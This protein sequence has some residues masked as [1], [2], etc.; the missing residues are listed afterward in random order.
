MNKRKANIFLVFSIISILLIGG[1]VLARSTDCFTVNFVNYDGTK[2]T[3]LQDVPLGTQLY[4]A[5]ELQTLLKEEFTKEDGASFYLYYDGG[6]S[7]EPWGPIAIPDPGRGDKYTFRDW[8]KTDQDTTLTVMSN[9]DFVARYQS[10]SCYVI[11]LYFQYDDENQV[12]AAQTESH[13][14]EINDDF[15]INIPEIEGTNRKIDDTLSSFYNSAANKFEG[16]LTEDTI[17]QLE[18]YTEIDNRGNTVISIPITYHFPTN[19][20]YTVEYYEQN[21]DGKTY[22]KYK[23]E[24]YTTDDAEV[25][26]SGM[27][28]VDEI[29]HFTLTEAS[30]ADADLYIVS[31]TGNSVIKLYYNRD[32]YWIY[33]DSRGGTY[34]E[35]VQYLYGQTIEYGYHPT[36]QGYSFDGWDYSYTEDGVTYNE[37][38]KTM[39]GGDVHLTAKWSEADTTYRIVYWIERIPTEVDSGLYYINKGHYEEAK[40][41]TGTDLHAALSNGELNQ[42]ISSHLGDFIGADKVNYFEFDKEETLK[43]N[44]TN[45]IASGDGM[46]TINVYFK[47][48]TYTL[49]FVLAKYSRSA[50]RFAKGTSAGT[51]GGADWPLNTT[52][53]WMSSFVTEKKPSITLNGKDVTE[54][55]TIDGV[56]YVVYNLEAKYEEYIYD[57]WPRSGV[58]SAD[59]GDNRVISWGTQNDSGYYATHTNKNILG[60]Y[61]EM[62]EELIINASDPSKIHY[63]V[64][65]C[66]EPRYFRYHVMTENINQSDEVSGSFSIYNGKRYTEFTN[67]YSYSTNTIS[68]QNAMELLGFDF[69]GR[70]VDTATQNGN[71]GSSDANHPVELYFYYDRVYHNITLYNVDREYKLTQYTEA[72]RDSLLKEYGIKIDNEGNVSVKTGAT[73]KELQQLSLE[74][75]NDNTNPLDYPLETLGVNKEWKFNGWYRNMIGT[76][77]ANDAYWNAE[78]QTDR[79]LYA[80][81]EPPKY[82]ITYVV[83]NGELKEDFSGLIKLDYTLEIK[84]ENNAQYITIGNIPEGTGT[85]DFRGRGHL[86]VNDFGLQF[87]RWVYN[88][89]GTDREYMFTD[90]RK[91][92]SDLVLT[93]QWDSASSGKYTAYYLTEDKDAAIDAD[94]IEVDGKVYYQL[95]TTQ[96]V[97]NLVYGHTIKATAIE[98]PGYLARSATQK[99]VLDSDKNIYFIYDKAGENITYYVHYV[100]DL[101]VDYGNTQPPQNAE[102]LM[103]ARQVDL[104]DMTNRASVVES[105]V[106]ISGYTPRDGWSSKLVLSSDETMNHLYIYY[107]KNNATS[108][109]RIHYYFMDD[110][111]KYLTENAKTYTFTGI[112]PVGQF[113]YAK[114]WAS[115]YKDYIDNPSVITEIDNCVA[116]YKLDESLSDEYTVVGSSGTALEGKETDLYIYM[117]IHECTIT[118]IDS[119]TTENE[120]VIAQTKVERESTLKAEQLQ[121]APE[122]DGYAFKGWYKNAECTIPYN[123]ESEED[124]RIMNKENYLYAGW[125]QIGTMPLDENDK[126]NDMA[127]EGTNLGTEFGLVGVQ[128]RTFEINGFKQG[129]RFI[130][131]IGDTLVKD[132][133]DLNTK[134]GSLKP[135]D[136]HQK[137]VGYGTVVTMKKILPANAILVKDET[138]TSVTRGNV[139]VPAVVTFAKGKGYEYYSAVI[140]DMPVK[141]YGERA[142]VRPYITY[143]DCNGNIQDYYYTESGDKAYGKGYS[144]S[145]IETTDY[146]LNGGFYENSEFE[147]VEFLQKIQEEYQAY[148]STK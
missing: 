146:V 80:Q 74:W 129:L 9:I 99:F 130:S 105:A 25:S 72:Q 88:D 104:T 10:K 143:Y 71:Y 47:R 32:T 18:K 21:V 128:I 30:V 41:V 57:R 111:G 14:Y 145:Y 66:D 96:T 38:P 31:G 140:I 43:R 4:S 26:I 91:L 90:S 52:P 5:K 27:G 114:E 70:V 37:Q 8:K 63:M 55:K 62:S 107:T 20:P 36:R 142:V 16:K 87:K 124:S 109:F 93:A 48:K 97:S 24:T 138:A 112:A 61:G 115:N 92:Y 84:K 56:Q 137:G 77:V 45:I 51:V 2:T 13:S 75:E 101:G 94:A 73:L 113:L 98:I 33:R 79:V 132:L 148:L 3:T 126:I 134:N 86:P 127:A 103:E 133:E 117:E 65:F 35:P 67:F 125:R 40:T 89:N 122:H 17:K 78:V 50:Y 121:S 83:P 81:W 82:S 53:A 59:I 28:C 85:Y 100:K 19:T 68:N 29:P 120:G 76:I 144:I 141:V 23:T 119:L 49:C 15:S 131:C 136:S 7:D 110:V 12:A 22:R 34:Y 116:G 58:I 11:N 60:N 102:E 123:P 39:P 46:S 1:A 69:I 95:K 139:V 44:N 147:S 108:K 6:G 54:I 118:Y 64:A 106:A 135:K 42:E